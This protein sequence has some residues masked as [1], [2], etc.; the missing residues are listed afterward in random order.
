MMPP[1]PCVP[2]FLWMWLSRTTR[3]AF[4]MFGSPSSLIPAEMPPA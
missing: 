3:L 1:A 2:P 4:V